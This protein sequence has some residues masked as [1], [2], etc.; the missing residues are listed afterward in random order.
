MRIRYA[1]ANAKLSA[2]EARLGVTV[3]SFD[4]LSGV[5][6]PFAQ[7]CHSKV[8]VRADGSR[9]IQD[10]KRTLFRCFSASQE[11]AYTNVF[12][13]GR[14]EIKPSEISPVIYREFHERLAAG[15]C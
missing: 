9:S 13:G 14:S 3:Y 7:D 15:V 2:L 4:L 6:C 8:V 5:T 10:G 1:P 12:W 11:V